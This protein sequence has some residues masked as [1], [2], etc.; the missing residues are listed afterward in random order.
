VGGLTAVVR[1]ASSL[2]LRLT[3]TPA[4]STAALVADNLGH[5]LNT[6]KGCGSVF[7]EFGLGD[8]E[9]APNTHDAVI[10]LGKELRAVVLRYE[11]RL[12]EPEVTLRGRHGYRMIRFSITG[13]VDGQP[14][15]FAV[16][17]DTT[18]RHVDVWP[19]GER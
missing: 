14:Q 13:L 17:V 3:Q 8:Y 15:A 2:L 9:S 12:Q 5:V 19:E 10:V 7:P 18:D 11:P 6:R 1:Q 4:G 16:D